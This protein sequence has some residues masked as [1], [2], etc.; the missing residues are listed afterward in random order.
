MVRCLRDHRAIRWSALSGIPLACAGGRSAGARD[1]SG[2]AGPAA[3]GSA[4]SL[5]V[6]DPL[7][8]RLLRGAALLD[9]GER[10]LHGVVD[11]E[12][13]G[14]LV[15]RDR[16]GLGTVAEDLARWCVV[17]RG[18]LDREQ[19]RATER[20][21][22]AGEGPDLLE[23]GDLLLRCGQPGGELLGLLG[24]RTLLGDG[25]VGPAPV[26]SA[27]REGVGDV[28]ALDAL[29]VALDDADHPAGAEH[30]RETVLL[31]ARGP[32]FT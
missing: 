25:Q 30:R 11:G 20:L 23:G 24:V 29:G 28:P 3:L 22:L 6:A 10:L 17:E 13:V 21:D 5:H 32:V 7:V 12:V 14:A 2:P 15:G 1:V 27:T 31:E 9:A 16:D 18:D 26:A 8:P 4:E 19:V